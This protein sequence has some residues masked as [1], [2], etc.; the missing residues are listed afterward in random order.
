MLLIQASW[1]ARRA[2]RLRRGQRAGGGAQ[3]GGGSQL[4][5]TETAGRRSGETAGTIRKEKGDPSNHRL[6]EQQPG[7]TRRETR[8][9]Q[10]ERGDG[11]DRG[12]GTL[13]CAPN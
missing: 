11:A 13:I 4:S 10:M 8:A 5:Q 12:G 3:G 6:K 1:R 2:T 9:L 7:Q